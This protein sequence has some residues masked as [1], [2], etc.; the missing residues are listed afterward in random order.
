MHLGARGARL[1]PLAILVG[2]TVILGMFGQWLSRR[3]VLAFPMLR[4]TGTNL[5]AHLPDDAPR[6]WL[7][8]HLDT[9]SQPVPTLIRSAG[10]VALVLAALTALV[11]ALAAAAGARAPYAAWAATAVVTLIGGI[12]VILSVVGNHS[13]GALD[14]ASGVVTVVEAAGMLPPTRGVGILITDA[15]ELGLA[16]AR[17]WG[18]QGVG[19]IVLNCDGVDDSG[20]INVLYTGRP[21]GRVLSA[22]RDAS[23]ST[24][25]AHR[26]RTIPLGILMDSVAFSAAG[27]SAVTFSRGTWRSLA[28]VHRSADNLERLT[29]TGIGETATLMAA[30]ARMLLKEVPPTTTLGATR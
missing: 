19:M 7:C 24:H 13:P 14:N 27:L 22:A 3:G 17:A 29:G 23:A 20:P 30:T 26:A 9:K 4:T 28:R 6:V 1:F 11:L 15:E 8:A 2:A 12:P 18:G 21:P 25:V 5:E 16:G 10:V